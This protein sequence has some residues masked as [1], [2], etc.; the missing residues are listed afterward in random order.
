[1]GKTP[2]GWQV[3][4]D[5]VEEIKAK[6]DIMDNGNVFRPDDMEPV[7][8]P[9]LALPFECAGTSAAVTRRKVGE[10]LPRAVRAIMAVLLLL[11]L[12]RLEA[13]FDA[14]PRTHNDRKSRLSTTHQ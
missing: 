8:K 9:D 3:F 2:C 12:I 1:M 13:D 6:V 4:D 14:S 7:E 10:Q 5:I 11:A